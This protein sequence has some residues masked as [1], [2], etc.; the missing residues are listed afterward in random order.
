[1]NRQI[2]AITCW[3]MA[4][5]LLGTL[6]PPVML[7]INCLNYPQYEGKI[8]FSSFWHESNERIDNE[9]HGIIIYQYEADDKMYYGNKFGPS[10]D[11]HSGLDKG[12]DELNNEFRIG[13]AITVRGNIERPS[14]SVI[15]TNL[16]EN[17][18]VAFLIASAFSVIGS[19]LYKN[20]ANKSAHTTTAIAPR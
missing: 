9:I 7:W 19:I 2:A 13:K 14:L 1:M 10:G 16:D 3:L 17:L 6:L 18:I 11:F 5:V 12:L 15:S 20:K 4:A 8:A